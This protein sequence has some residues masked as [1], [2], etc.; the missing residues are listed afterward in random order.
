MVS[1]GD[2]TTEDLKTL[3]VG[4]IYSLASL[5]LFL[6]LWVAFL[7]LGFLVS[8]ANVAY[9][10]LYFLFPFIVLFVWAHGAFKRVQGWNLLR[11]HSYRGFY[12]TQ[13]V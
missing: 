9:E 12:I 10:A 2:Y 11:Q 6:L 1:E 5:V 13:S 3:R 8:G 4:F 7:W